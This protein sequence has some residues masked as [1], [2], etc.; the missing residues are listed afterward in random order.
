MSFVRTCADRVAVLNFGALI[1]DGEPAE[2]LRRPDVVAAYLGT[3]APAE[4]EEEPAER[5][6]ST[7]RAASTE[8]EGA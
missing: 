5:A 6:A 2:V 7:G 8:R 3:D 1:A 4:P